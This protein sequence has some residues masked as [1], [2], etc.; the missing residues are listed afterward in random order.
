MPTGARDPACSEGRGALPQHALLLLA[1]LVN[2]CYQAHSMRRLSS[3]DRKEQL[4]QA[5][6]A[7]A[8]CPLL[9]GC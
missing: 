9:L 2:L 1:Q 5:R 7:H 8:S 4:M 3:M 6:Q